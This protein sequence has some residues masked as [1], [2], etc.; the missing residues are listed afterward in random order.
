MTF[1][2][3]PLQFESGGYTHRYIV[4]QGPLEGTT[5]DFWQMIWEQDIQLILMLTNERVRD[6]NTQYIN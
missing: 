5:G 4:S 6:N 3:Y 1:L 2:G